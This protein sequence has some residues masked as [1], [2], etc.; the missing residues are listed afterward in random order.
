MLCE[1]KHMHT[2]THILF[3]TSCTACLFIRTHRASMCVC[4]YLFDV[5]C[6]VSCVCTTETRV[7][8]SGNHFYI[9]RRGTLFVKLCSLHSIQWNEYELNHHHNHHCK[10]IDDDGDNYNSDCSSNT[11]TAQTSFGLP[12]GVS[13]VWNFLPQ[14]TN[15]E[16]IATL[17]VDR[18][19]C[20]TIPLCV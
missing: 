3:V 16:H 8:C 10:C 4:V 7:S 14:R 11:T 15:V 19:N 13:S 9:K 5:V 2:F 6:V 20:G 18:K 12:F 1:D 17:P